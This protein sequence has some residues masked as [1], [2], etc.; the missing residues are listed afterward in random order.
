MKHKD[1]SNANG[2][3][4]RDTSVDPP[5]GINPWTDV[6]YVLGRATGDWG[7]LCGDV[8]K[9][10]RDVD[11]VNTNS[12]HKPVRSELQGGTE[13][14]VKVPA[15]Y[16][17]RID[18]KEAGANTLS[19]VQMLRSQGANYAHWGWDKPRGYNR[20]PQEFYR[21]DDFDGYNHNQLPYRT[22]AFL[23]RL[24]ASQI[25]INGGQPLEV[26]IPQSSTITKILTS[27][28]FVLNDAY[29]VTVLVTIKD[30]DP[31][32]AASYMEWYLDGELQ[33]NLLD[34]NDRVVDWDYQTGFGIKTGNIPQTI[35]L[36]FEGWHSLK[37]YTG[38]FRI[39]YRLHMEN[40]TYY[41]DGAND[42]YIP[43]TLKIDTVYAATLT[44]S[45]TGQDGV[46][47]RPGGMEAE[48][49]DNGFR[50]R[51]AVFGVNGHWP[52]AI[53]EVTDGSTTQ[54][55][56]CLVPNSGFIPFRR[57]GIT[58]QPREE[59]SA[60]DIIVYLLYGD[61]SKI[62]TDI[63][64]Q[65]DYG[66]LSLADAQ[67][68]SCAP[69]CYNELGIIPLDPPAFVFYQE[70]C[71]G[72]RFDYHDGTYQQGMTPSAGGFTNNEKL[73]ERIRM[74][75]DIG[76]DNVPVTMAIDMHLDIYNSDDELI[77]SDVQTLIATP[78][79]WWYGAAHFDIDMSQQSLS[80]YEIYGKLWADVGGDI[81][82]IKFYPQ[83]V[84]QSDPG[85][86]CF[87]WQS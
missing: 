41:S 78:A 82:Y 17:F 80:P 54:R 87:G 22:P 40:N 84:S 4:Y 15:K 32:S 77:E 85:L 16:G 9:D 34:A 50:A 48:W 28:T 65:V 73:V 70:D 25:S 52:I 64:H 20:N 57:I 66:D 37:E 47:V 68:L 26:E 60:K 23:T 53:I 58:V 33:I 42:V 11:K 81:Y 13:Q 63:E 10:G 6:S 56:I 35:S 43:V 36:H 27:N 14:Q 76:A 39:Q 51:S 62:F 72:A 7:Q 69:N 24:T 21:I 74:Q 8:D 86:Y 67:V 30:P 31:E 19:F 2:K 18:T 49:R 3:I 46:V 12:V 83:A 61:Y 44:R 29:D 79:T 45:R 55:K 71:Q 5:F 59:T 1:M 38:P 75:W